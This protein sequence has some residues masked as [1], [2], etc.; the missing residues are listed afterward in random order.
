M[1]IVPTIASFLTHVRVEKG[2]SQNTVEAYRRDLAKF[3]GYAK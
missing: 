1:E 3:E 2:L